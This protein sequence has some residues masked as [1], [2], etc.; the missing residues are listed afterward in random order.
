[1]RF[2]AG[3]VELTKAMFL[4]RLDPQDVAIHIQCHMDAW[5]IES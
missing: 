2:K 4:D 1:M 3:G 5:S